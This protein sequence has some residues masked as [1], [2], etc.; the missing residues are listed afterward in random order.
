M[1]SDGDFISSFEGE[2]DD[3][4][5][6]RSIGE[7]AAGMVGAILAGDGQDRAVGAARSWERMDAGGHDQPR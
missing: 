5:S 7:I 6:W 4:C 3:E 2:D 1:E